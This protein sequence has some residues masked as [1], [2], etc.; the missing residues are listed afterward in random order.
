M[1]VSPLNTWL[2]KHSETSYEV[3]VASVDPKEESIHEFEG[4]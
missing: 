4:V 3:L 2:I 1:S